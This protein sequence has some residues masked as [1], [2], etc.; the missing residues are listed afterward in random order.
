MTRS[1]EDCAIVLRVIAGHDGKDP[2]SANRAVP[3]YRAA[4]NAD[5]RG[6][7]IGVIRHF[8][9]EDAPVHG[10]MS[11]AMDAAL[12][13][14]AG[15][16]AKLETVRVRPL[17]DYYDVA[18]TI[19]LPEMVSIHRKELL[20]RPADFSA[21]F[22]IRGGL[23]A[24]LF[25]SSDY[26]D[27]QRERRRMI[28]E[29]KPLY[30]Q[31][32]VF[33]TP[34]SAGPAPRLDSYRSMSY[35][36][37][38]NLTT[39]FSIT[40]G[41]ALVVCNGFT[42]SGL[43]LGMQIGTKPFGEE[44]VLKVGHA[45]EQATTWHSEHPVLAAD[46]IPARISIDSIPRGT[47]ELDDATLTLVKVMARRAGLNLTESQFAELCHSAPY[48]IAMIERIRKCRDAGEEPASV[49]RAADAI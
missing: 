30:D 40:G 16:G 10:E 24:C 14:L 42:R 2:T 18:K 4:L 8:W 23:G 39:I 22:R 49:F 43:P 5:I 15:L 25:Q 13:V 1:V 9:E 35:W 37:R 6:L 47:P 17:N 27:A 46:A 31:Y 12:G 38:P 28:A 26:V 32:D 3:D 41:P 48:V 33:V 11:E 19:A 20:E 45:Y 36:Q 44:Q 7:R 34:A 21:D 29:V